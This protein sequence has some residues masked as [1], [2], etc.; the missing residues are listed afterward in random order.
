[1]SKDG[2]VETNILRDPYKNKTTD[3]WLSSKD[4]IGVRIIP[5]SSEN[6]STSS[7]TNEERTRVVWKNQRDGKVAKK[8]ASW[9]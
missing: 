5:R 3:R 7:E 4:W 2:W 8:V 1:M 6:K 9:S